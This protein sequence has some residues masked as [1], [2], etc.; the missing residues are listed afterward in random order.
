MADERE[1]QYLGLCA[2]DREHWFVADLENS[3]STWLRCV[4]CGLRVVESKKR[5]HVNPLEAK[6][7][8][9]NASKN[10]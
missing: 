9:V 8:R 4:N 2:H 1:R 7:T 6:G 3:K 5:S 10:F